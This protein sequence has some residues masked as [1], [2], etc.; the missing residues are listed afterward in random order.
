MDRPGKYDEQ[1]KAAAEARRNAC[2]VG[3]SSNSGLTTV[4]AVDTAKEEEKRRRNLEK[5]ENIEKW[6]KDVNRYY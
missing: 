6:V 1:K 2:N 5:R 3:K 4:R